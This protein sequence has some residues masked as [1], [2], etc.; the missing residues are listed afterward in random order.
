MASKSALFYP[1]Y[2]LYELFLM[3]F[4]RVSPSWFAGFSGPFENAS[5]SL[6]LP[7]CF[8]GI[9]YRFGPHILLIL[10][11]VFYGV[12][13]LIAKEIM[14]RYTG[15]SALILIRVLATLLLFGLTLLLLRLFKS[16]FL[17]NARLVPAREDL[18][19]FI[20][21]GLSGVAV[22]QLLFYEGLS[23]TTPINAAII[24]TSNP[25]LTLLVSIVLLKQKAGLVKWLGMITGGTGA[26]GLIILSRGTAD[27]SGDTHLGNLM[28]FLNALSYALYLALAKP[29]MQKYNPLVVITWNFFFGT[30]FVLPFAWGQFTR[31]EWQLFPEH[32]WWGIL[33]T[34]LAVTYFAYLASILAL[35]KLQPFQVSVYVY[36]Q[37]AVAALLALYLG[38]D[39]LSAALVAGGLLIFTG[40]YFV[41]RPEGGFLKKRY[42]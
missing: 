9:M 35:K 26:V 10:V 39:R 21:C 32:V 28:V 23:Y 14:P 4:G 12:N 38:K 8:P 15:P 19:R 37:P 13:F 7:L 3:I 36:L 24:F 18:P 5:Y 42:L 16:P 11:N 33:F 25:L 6:L 30:F 41:I 29:L 27:F 17:Y 40:V 20:L 2:A 22:N 34:V 1:K 31:I